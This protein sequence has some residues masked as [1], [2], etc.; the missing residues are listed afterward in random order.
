VRVPFCNHKL[1]DLINPINHKRKT[2]P[3]T[4]AILKSILSKSYSDEFV[5]RPKNAFRLPI[6]EWSRDKKLMGQYLDYLTDDTFRQRGIYDVNVVSDMLNA[7]M[8]E[9]KNYAN[10]I[11]SLL[12]LEIWARQ[13]GM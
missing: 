6:K 13:A 5:Y 12:S 4:K 7:H 8:K 10:E 1:F 2:Q 11:F 9:E 3:V